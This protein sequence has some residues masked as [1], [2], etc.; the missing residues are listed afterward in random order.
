[1][2]KRL[3]IATFLFLLATIPTI[4]AKPSAQR[5]WASVRLSASISSGAELTA[6]LRTFETT[7][8][9]YFQARAS[10]RTAIPLSIYIPGQADYFTLAK[11]W[12]SLSKT[13]I[14][15]YAMA[16]Q[17]PAGLKTYSSPGGNF[18]IVYSDTGSD[19][20]DITD[21]IGY[22]AANWRVRTHGPN[23]IPDYVELIAYAADSAWAMEIDHFGFVKPF[24]YIG[25]GYTSSRF[26][27]Y[28]R[29]FYGSESGDYGVTVP[30]GQAPGSI[31]FRCHIEIR[32]EWNESLWNTSPLDYTT[33]PEKAIRV[34]CVH[35]FFH[36]SQYAMT[37]QLVD[38]YVPQDFPVSWIEGTAVLM[39]DCGFNY[40][41]DYLQYVDDYFNDPTVQV[42][43]PVDYDISLYKNSIVAMFLYQQATDSACICFI[44]NMF[45]NEYRNRVGFVNNLRACAA[46][47][48]RTWAD[49]LGS[50]H[51]R[52]YYSG[53]RSVIGRFIGDAALLPQWSYSVG[54]AGNS[55]PL[56][57]T[58]EPFG[59]NTFSFSHSA[60]NADTLAVGFLGDSLKQGEQD[61]NAIWSVHC[62]LK[63]D[64]VPA[65]DSVFSIPVFSVCKA[66]TR[67]PGWNKYT[68]ALV[69]VSNAWYDASRKATVTFDACGTTVRS[70]ETAV[71]AVTSGAP[72]S[73]QN[74]TVTVHAN[75]DL[76]CSMSIVKTAAGSRQLDSATSLR[77]AAAGAF[78]S[79]SMPLT[80]LYDASMD[81]A[82]SEPVD[83]IRFGIDSGAVMDSLLMVFRWDSTLLQW[84]RCTATAS[85][86][87][88]ST[89]TLRCPVTTAG[90]YGLFGSM[91]DT[92]STVVAFPNPVRLKSNGAISFRGRDILEIWI[93]G[94]DGSLVS[95]GAKGETL[96]PSLGATK[97]GFSWK[98]QSARGRTV[99]P[100]VYYAYV[101][102]KDLRTKG[103][104]KTARK[105]FVVP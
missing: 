72:S 20:V 38:G 45:F 36:T 95:H 9:P 76:S 33:H 19:S 14:D 23:G 77:L 21:T 71:Y 88:D 29:G 1:L 83:S 51:T 35:E 62:I 75:A 50:F 94:I 60:G 10:G 67:I 34:T 42:L 8:T 81:L 24:P 92:A 97:D 28:V 47:Y 54:D 39:E 17:I 65:D 93:Y 27:I 11:Y 6:A 56:V 16:M 18:E 90:I 79:V 84:Q 82:I 57:K 105:V 13:F 66:R 78:F 52:S 3:A 26:R 63:K 40:V 59:M 22:S 55:Q 104:K 48:N 70:G 102:F 2:I 37:R 31:G 15:L 100:G 12:S 7:L 86:S 44:K 30:D 89:F 80:W 43:E 68:E 32:N 25:N 41:H 96:E 69:I 101:G 49:L 98:L 53:T 74:A 85:L 5:A 103:M 99:S 64:G 91:Q 61:T 73:A 87:A 46:L 4:S 58:V